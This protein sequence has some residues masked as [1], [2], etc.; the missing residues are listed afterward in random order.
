MKLKKMLAV[1]VAVF[2]LAIGIGGCSSSGVAANEVLIWAITGSD[3]AAWL[4]EMEREFEAE[5]SD[6][7]IVVRATFA[8]YNSILTN[9]ARG[10]SPDIVYV[11]DEYFKRYA[12]GGFI[13]P[14]DDLIEEYWADS[15]LV[16][17]SEIW[18]PA[19]ARYRYEVSN[20]TS[21]ADDPLYCIPKDMDPTVLYYNEGAFEE[22]G[23]TVISVDEED[24][25]AW[26]ADKIA[27]ANGKKKSDYE[28]LAGIGDV[29]ARGY[30]RSDGNWV[31]G[32][33]WRAPE[34][35]ATLVFNNRIP[36]S[37]DEV[38]DLAML[39]TDS[40]NPGVSPTTYGYYTE[41]WFNYGWSVGGDCIGDTTGN[42]DY[43]FTLN[44]DAPNYKVLKAMNVNGTDYAPG[45]D[46]VPV[47]LSYEDK[48]FLAQNSSVADGLVADGSIEAYPST[49][50]AFTRFCALSRDKTSSDPTGLAVS[51]KPSV[52][53][54]ASDAL[55]RF[56]TGGDLAMFVGYS[57]YVASIS[58]AVDWNIAPLP[59]YKTYSGYNT[60]G[61]FGARAGHSKS[62]GLA[63]A[64]DSEKK[65]MA[66]QVL[67]YLSGTPGQSALAQQHYYLPNTEEVAR[68]DYLTDTSKNYEQFLVETRYQDP[69]DWWY[70]LDREWIANWSEPLNQNPNSVRNS[71]MTLT[72][73]FNTVVAQTNRDLQMY[74][75]ALGN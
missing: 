72:Q 11:D 47:F 1:L 3:N 67:A 31:S 41:W 22:L 68:T 49:L 70:M 12:D 64:A 38:E 15:E 51:P 18:E 17:V 27:D 20:N 29:P 50:D 36:M 19:L 73:Y 25:V 10:N 57:S 28:A 35:S 59:V 43:V 42:G 32:T 58:D 46:D 52:V 56:N 75:E 23:I 34:S 45:T 8:D 44:D 69:G 54:T 53:P 55:G 40:Y 16:D 5:N 2:I 13:A 71:G 4:T 33:T 9:F 74:K 37:W 14:L 48:Q 7:G 65:E 6:I 66:M 61:Q 62:T 60:V 21:D 39:C 63:I 26:N 30:W 24:L